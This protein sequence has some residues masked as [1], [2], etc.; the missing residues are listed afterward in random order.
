[1]KRFGVIVPQKLLGIVVSIYQNDKRIFGIISESYFFLS[2]NDRHVTKIE[3]LQGKLFVSKR[4]KDFRNMRIRLSDRTVSVFSL[5]TPS[6][7]CF[8][9]LCFM[10]P[11]SLSSR[12]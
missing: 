12:T 10:I 2:L 1:V 8:C 11:Q 3:A 5:S 4:Q 6:V 9:V 7:S